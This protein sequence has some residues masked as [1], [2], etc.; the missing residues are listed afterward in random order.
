M[1]SSLLTPRLVTG[2]SLIALLA[3]SLYAGGVFLFLMALVFSSLA[4]WEFYNLV[5]PGGQFTEKCS[6]LLASTVFLLCVGYARIPL[7][8]IISMVVLGA[9]CMFLF[10][11]G[12]N[13]PEYPL[14]RSAFLIAGILYISLPVAFALSLPRAE[15]V[16]LFVIPAVTDTSAY[17]IG[18]RF[19]SHKIWPAVSPKK[20]IEGCLAGLCA[21][22][23][24]GGLYS[25][26]VSGHS[27]VFGLFIG[28][29]LSLAAMLGDFFESAIKRSA[30]VKDSG[31]ILPGHGGVLDRVDSFLFV[32][33]TYIFFMSA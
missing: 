6:G 16:F 7:S 13:E 12:R 31:A 9:F 29:A 5:W 4:L 14:S 26:Y 3:L 27:L 8:A 20:S 21:G 22:M 19:G 28:F 25:Q 32:V 18:M 10:R 11:F 15:L 2:L 30:G 24:A 1:N 23:L 17:Y 33:P